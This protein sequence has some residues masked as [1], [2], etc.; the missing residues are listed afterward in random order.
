M[1]L[2]RRRFPL[3]ESEKRRFL[4]DLSKRFPDVR[5]LIGDKPQIEVVGTRESEVFIIDGK[6]LL[7]RVY[8][9]IIPSLFIFE[10]L[11]SLLPKV[12]VDM[13]AVPHICN[14]ADVMAPGI[15]RIEGEFG[16]G[17]YVV[18]LDERYGKAI[19]VAKALIN[20]EDAKFIRHGKVF[21][22]LHYVGDSC[23][24]VMREIYSERKG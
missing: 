17:D 13:G 8:G 5:R 9:E 20:S 22:N 1:S 21:R 23:W 16:E 24:R 14:G 15:V 4:E 12:I 2:I 19:A 6:P 11:T 7:V 18:V 10:N 3:R